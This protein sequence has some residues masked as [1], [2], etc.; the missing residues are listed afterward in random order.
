MQNEEQRLQQLQAALLEVLEEAMSVDE[1]ACGK[2]RLYNP[3]SRTL[4]ITAQ[5]GFSDDFVQS[6]RAID[7]DEELACAR[8]FRLR[9]CVT[10]PNV[11]TDPLA[12]PYRESARG[13]G[14]K[15]FQSTPLIGPDGRVVGTLSTHFPRV[16]HPSTSA[17]LVLDYLSAKAA[18]LIASLGGPPPQAA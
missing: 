7:A 16:H 5:R 15:A 4:D 13:E 9:R 6:F 2:I 11:S 10:V 12:R 8:A 18:A 14:F 17:Q 1:A 3:Q